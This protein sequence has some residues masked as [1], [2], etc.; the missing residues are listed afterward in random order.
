MVKS[1]P[2]VRRSRD[3]ARSAILEA[4]AKRLREGGPEAVRVQHV[5][6]D[7]GV[8]DAAIHHHFGSREG[9]MRAL[10]R[11][12][13]QHLRDELNDILTG[14]DG[15]PARLQQ[16]VEL[17]ADVYGE[18]GYAR[19]ALWL[20]LSGTE[21]TGRGLFEPLVDVVHRARLRAARERGLPKPRRLDAQ[22][23][24]AMLNVVLAGEPLF[25]APFL[26]S[27][28]LEDDAS[29]EVQFRRWVVRRWARQLAGDG[30]A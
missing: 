8:T 28:G 1:K 9:L 7:V 16:V 3:E 14:W 20:A 4:A 29:S 11:F 26:R 21:S 13:G 10:L 30:D 17:I 22:H 18:Q 19:L 23:E 5:A 15:D 25:G 2:R 24:V 6:A 12:A 27:V